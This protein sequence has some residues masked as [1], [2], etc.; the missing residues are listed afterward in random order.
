[1]KLTKAVLIFCYC[2]LALA[3]F[4]FIAYRLAPLA[5]RG[6]WGDPWQWALSAYNLS[7]YTALIVFLRRQLRKAA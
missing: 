4:I 5:L 6:E 1:V 3:V 7:V 2:G